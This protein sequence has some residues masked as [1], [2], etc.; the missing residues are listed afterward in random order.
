MTYTSTSHEYCFLESG[1]RLSDTDPVTRVGVGGDFSL[2]PALHPGTGSTRLQNRPAQETN[3]LI[4]MILA[5][6][7]HQ[8]TSSGTCEGSIQHREEHSHT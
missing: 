8:R 6:A 3:A 2:D 7:S 4:P 5:I 1:T